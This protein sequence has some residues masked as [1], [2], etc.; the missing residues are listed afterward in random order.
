MYTQLTV[1]CELGGSGFIHMIG[2][3][4][5]EISQPDLNKV[6]LG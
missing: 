1:P 3:V 5:L 4:E 2:W 6:E